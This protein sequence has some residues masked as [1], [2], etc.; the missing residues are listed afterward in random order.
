M[1]VSPAI[2]DNDTIM[3]NQHDRVMGNEAQSSRHPLTGLIDESVRLTSRLRSVFAPVRQAVGLNESE[4]M[5]LNAVVE[6]QVPPTVAQIGRSMGQARQ[7]VQRAANSL[8][9]AGLIEMTDN[10]DHRRASLLRPTD[11][12]RSLKQDIDARAEVIAGDLVDEAD[13]AAIEEAAQVLRGVRRR[14]ERRVR[15]Q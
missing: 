11:K 15:D 2:F 14:I 9:D 7:L 6:A 13:L 12:G 3:S 10:P 8:R 1:S 4:Q 5:V